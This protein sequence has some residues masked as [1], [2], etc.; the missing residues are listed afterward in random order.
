[1][2]TLQD[3]LRE[4]KNE[5]NLLSTDSCRGLAEYCIGNFPEYFWIREASSSG[6]YHPYSDLGLGG[7]IRHT[8][9][10]M[11]MFHTII[12]HPY[13]Q[14]KYNDY[15]RDCGLV[16]LLIH[17]SI[18]YG[19]NREHTVHEHPLLVRIGLD[20]T[21]EHPEW[22]NMWN[23][24]CDLV[25]THM[26]VWNKNREGEEILPTPQ[27]ELQWLVHFADYLAS[28]RYVEVTTHMMYETMQSLA[29]SAQINYIKSLEVQT[30]RKGIEFTPMSYKTSS[31]ASEYIN[32][33]KNLG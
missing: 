4:F 19:D 14:E 29:S 24:V 25:E 21:E 33:L 27:T 17:D 9:A 18:K 3:K 8:K 30:K 23:K 26:G 7:L 5:L 22:E 31:Q 20:P 13:F 10:N 32:Y 1:M 12:S 16:A 15:D 2:I 28:R 6:K 11:V